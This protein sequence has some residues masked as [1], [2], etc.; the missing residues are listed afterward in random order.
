MTKYLSF[1]F[2]RLTTSEYQLL[3]TTVL[4]SF[5]ETKYELFSRTHT[6]FQLQFYPKT[7]QRLLGEKIDTQL[8]TP[9]MLTVLQKRQNQQQIS[10]GLLMEN[11]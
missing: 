8:E 10:S 5:V 4:N 7:A 9:S 1:H 11:Q 6:I 2:R 3:I